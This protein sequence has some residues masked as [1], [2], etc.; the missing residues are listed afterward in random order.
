MGVA[1]WQVT[2]SSTL[3]KIFHI[4]NSQHCK[5]RKKNQKDTAKKKEKKKKT[6]YIRRMCWWRYHGNAAVAGML[7][8]LFIWPLLSHR[9][10]CH[11]SDVQALPC[12]EV[13]KRTQSLHQ[14]HIQ[15]RFVING[16]AAMAT[17]GRCPFPGQD[18]DRKSRP[19]NRRI[20]NQIF[21]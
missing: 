6:R 12:Q 16:A 2:W 17:P 4:L 10:W 5:K 13:F 21:F 14:H 7:A 3:L 11:S 18:G 1:S 20:K 8:A 19:W 15:V 9:K